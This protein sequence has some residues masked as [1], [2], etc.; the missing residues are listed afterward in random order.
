MDAATKI[1]KEVVM[2]KFLMV[3][4]ILALAAPAFAQEGGLQTTK[5]TMQ[6]GGM[7][8]FVIH[9]EMPDQGDS[10]TG[11]RLDVMPNVG[12]FL[13]DNLELQGALLFD[14][15][16]GDLYENDSKLLG[17]AVGARYFIPMGSFDL[18]LGALIG[19]GFNIP[20]EGDTTKALS[21]N[22]PVGLA[23]P[24][25]THVALDLGT[26]ITYNMSLEDGGGSSLEIPIGFLG[27]EGFF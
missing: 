9:T 21:I 16:F 11:F 3:G 4:M 18:Y 13:A 22:V 5:G 7:A 24:L 17:F 23:I 25:N 6:L 19:M 27:V 20:K 15:G 8:G 2:K 10:Q 26:Q 12:Y 1:S 14:M